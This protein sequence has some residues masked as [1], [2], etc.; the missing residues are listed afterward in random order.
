MPSFA[1]DEKADLLMRALSTNL[2]LDTIERDRFD[3][4]DLTLRY[5]DKGEGIHNLGDEVTHLYCITEGWITAITTMAN[6]ERQL[7]NFYVPYDIIGFEYLGRATATSSLLASEA[8]EVIAVPIAQFKDIVFSQ[9][10]LAA[11]VTSLMSRKYGALQ[12]RLCV[13]ANG[14]AT[15]KVAHFLQGLRSKQIRNG[16]SRPNL[17]RIPL[18]QLDMADALGMTNATVSRVFTKLEKDGCI[19]FKSGNIEILDH[20]KLESLTR[21]T[22]GSAAY[23]DEF[24]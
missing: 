12:T 10:D 24:D 16:F 22:T 11:A 13:M 20:G 8:V 14:N 6:G 17:L 5:F 21:A 4:T 1:T 3:Q 9:P 7:M 15:S 18:T 23:I 2:G 19:K